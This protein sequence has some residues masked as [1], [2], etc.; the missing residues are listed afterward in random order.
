MS[1]RNVLVDGNNLIHRAYAVFVKDRPP[2]DV[3]T[4]PSGYPT[5]LIYGI[6]SM[7]SDWVPE[8]SNPTR[9]AFFLDGRPAR[10]LALDPTYKLKDKQDRPGSAP[11]QIELSDGFVAATEMEVV[12]HLLSLLGVDVY[13]HPDEE[14][15]DLIASYVSS[16]PDD[17][18]VIMSSDIDFYQLL[19]GNDRVVLFRPGTGSNRFFDAER[20][21][22]HL[23]NK[24][25]VR[26]PPGNVRMFKAL[27]GDPSDGIS[28]VPRLR[29]KVAAPLCHHKSVDDLFSTGLPKFSDAER[30]KTEA[31]RDQIRLNY[32]L[33]GL[34]SSLNLSES[35]I[36]S[37]PD[38]K[39]ASKILREDLGITTIFPHAF[40]FGKSRVRTSSPTAYDLLPDF[41]KD[42]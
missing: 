8:I 18:H 36:P 26:V 21:E 13:H 19:E 39:S 20:A 14:A 4:S 22:E 29:K 12:V 41:L 25:K 30:E 11:C 15:D 38:P 1:D 34:D 16:R 33:I 5:G 2:H 23:L 35:R 17:M 10:R 7:L 3:L 40:E 42:I 28:G 6:F 31:M 32:E 27:T 24:F 37:Q 9:M